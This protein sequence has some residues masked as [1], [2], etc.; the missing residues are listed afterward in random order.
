[1]ARHQ[2]PK[3][4]ICPLCG[5]STFL[6]FHH[7]IPRKVHRRAHFKKH[8]D[9]AV[10]QQGLAICRACHNGIHRHYDEM[11]LAK[12]L[13]TPEKLSADPVLAAHFSW[14]AK[15]KVAPPKSAE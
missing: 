9:K 10:L 4:G 2:A 12:H 7:L 15:Q 8:V 6:T 11:H 3:N 5:R 13:N 14:V 1:M